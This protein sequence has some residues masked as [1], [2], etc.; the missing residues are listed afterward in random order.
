M[1]DFAPARR[2]ERPGFTDAE[3]REIVMEHECSGV[4]PFQGIDPLLIISRP[5]GDDGQAL[6][7][8]AGKQGRAMR[9]RQHPDFAS[10]WTDISR[11]TA[12]GSRSLFEDH[13]ADFRIFQTM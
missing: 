8:A 3:R 5:Q 4:L 12:V 11:S 9:A 10:D 1:T 7:F 2:P 6:R 13:I